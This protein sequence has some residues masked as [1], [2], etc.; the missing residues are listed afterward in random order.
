M[1]VVNKL[2][3]LIIWIL[4]SIYEG[5]REAYYYQVLCKVNIYYKNIHWIYFLQRGLFLIVIGFLFQ[6]FYI[7]L[8]LALIFPFFHDGFYYMKYNDLDPKVYIRR[9][10]SSSI[11]STAVLEF[12]W[13]T[14]YI[15]FIIGVLL[16]IFD[17]IIL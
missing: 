16:F 7:L 2:I 10:T 3:V 9:F 17:I 5:K 11:T 13:F 8:S 12:N 15:M 4:Y 1:E 6:D 14:R